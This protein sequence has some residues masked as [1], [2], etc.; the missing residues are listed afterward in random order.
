M[1]IYGSYIN[2][3][4]DTGFIVIKADRG[5]RLFYRSGPVGGRQI[6]EVLGMPPIVMPTASEWIMLDFTS[7]KLPKSGFEIKLSDKG[8]GWGEWS[9]IAVS[10]STK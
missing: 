8:A 7:P 2:S 10:K 3:D 9:A 6:L 1:K 4:S 5:D